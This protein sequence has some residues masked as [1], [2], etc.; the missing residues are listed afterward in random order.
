MLEPE[1]SRNWL[2]NTGS[3]KCL[4]VFLL[5]YLCCKSQAVRVTMHPKNVA[6]LERSCSKG[7]LH[8]WKGAL[9]L[10]KDNKW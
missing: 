1:N 2:T 3:D 6:D 9:F 8:L 10:S 7:L 5:T 4:Y